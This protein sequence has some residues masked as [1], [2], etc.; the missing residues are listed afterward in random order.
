MPAAAIDRQLTTGQTARALGVSE[1]RVRQL[2]RDGVL[3]PQVTPLGMLFSP[4]EVGCVIAQ[5]EAMQRERAAGRPRNR[6]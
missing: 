3:H 4:E 1:N 2:A 6:C 5:R